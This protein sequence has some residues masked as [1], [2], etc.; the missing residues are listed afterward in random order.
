MNVRTLLVMLS[1]AVAGMASAGEPV[2]NL[3][4]FEKDIQA[5]LFKDAKTGNCMKTLLGTRILPGNDNLASVAGQLDD[6]LVKWLADDKIFAMHVLG[7][8]ATG[9]I[10]DRRVYM[11]EDTSGALMLF[12]LAFLKR[13]G[14]WYVLKF[15]LDS[16]SDAIKKALNEEG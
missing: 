14:K 3:D 13:L 9:D 8:K 6:L 10:Y 1:M 5:C 7:R 12:E 15:N 16:N 11:L 2:P 4:A